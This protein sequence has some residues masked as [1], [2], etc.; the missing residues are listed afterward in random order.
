MKKKHLWMPLLMTILIFSQS[1]LSG[2]LSGA[3]SG[4]ITVFVS[5][6]LS[7]FGFDIPFDTLSILIRKFAHF[8][9]Y[10]FLG[11]LWMFVIFDK[12]YVKIGVKYALL[13]SLC[14][15]ALDE[16]IQLCVPGRAGSIVD[17]MIDMAGAITG[18]LLLLIFKDRR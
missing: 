16:T 6:I 8:V 4:R 15:A 14:T 9:E 10:F 18:I 12:A 2:E 11:F 3:Q 17:V 13:I 7:V 1:L 5:E